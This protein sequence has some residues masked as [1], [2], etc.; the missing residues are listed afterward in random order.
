MNFNHGTT[1]QDIRKDGEVMATPYK[2]AARINNYFN[3]KEAWKDW[4]KEEA[5]AR[6]LGFYEA[7][8]KYKPADVSGWITIDKRTERLRNYMARREEP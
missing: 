6:E 2:N 1:S 7:I 3:T 4:C 8:K 5:L